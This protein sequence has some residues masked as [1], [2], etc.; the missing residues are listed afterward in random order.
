P[1]RVV[2]AQLAATRGRE[3]AR[4]R[5]GDPRL[6][7][8]RIDPRASAAGRQRPRRLDA[9]RPALPR[10]VLAPR[11]RLGRGL[12]R[13]VPLRGDVLLAA[14]KLERIDPHLEEVAVDPVRADDRVALRERLE[15]RDAAE[16]RLAIDPQAAVASG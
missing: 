2:A 9:A 14:R 6:R 4:V 3:P 13:L 10:R 7:V 1:A 5:R 15:D 16:R 11:A 8:R 12:A